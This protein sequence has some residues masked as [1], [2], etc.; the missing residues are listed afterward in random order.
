M[1]EFVI[2]SGRHS[3]GGKMRLIAKMNFIKNKCCK[4]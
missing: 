3:N 1:L 2:D 4:S